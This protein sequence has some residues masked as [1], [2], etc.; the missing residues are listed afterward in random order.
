[1]ER[2]VTGGPF[3]AESVTEF[4][5]TASDGSHVKH[6]T[7]AVVARDSNGRT[8]YS[9][10]LSPLLPGAPR[11]FTTIRDPIAGIRYWIDPNQKVAQREFIR[12][13]AS[14]NEPRSSAGQESGTP[15]EAAIKVARQSLASLLSTSGGAAPGR[16][17]HPDTTS[18]GDQT[19]EGVAA[20][21]ARVSA[22][23]PSGQIGNEKPLTFA[24]EAWYS[25]ELRIIVMSKVSDPVLGDTTFQLTHLRRV[26]PDSSLFEVPSGYRIT[27]AGASSGSG[28]GRGKE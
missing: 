20:T 17:A 24:A 8:R 11:I 16:S 13:P 9:Q 1:L 3:S 28:P 19:I 5:Q 10:N 18:L 27:G 15:Q 25:Q 4:L 23:V 14:G 7:T 21:G 2:V 22:V 12:A 26:E 6:T